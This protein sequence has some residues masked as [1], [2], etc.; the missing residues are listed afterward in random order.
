MNRRRFPAPWKAEQIEGGY[1]IVDA[2]GFR[3]AYV[4]SPSNFG[5]LGTVSAQHLSPDEARRIAG[6]IARLPELL[7]DKK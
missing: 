3:L 6:A 2:N 5:E 7:A 1:R 4:Y